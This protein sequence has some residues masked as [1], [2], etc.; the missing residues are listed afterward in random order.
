MKSGVHV[1]RAR[2]KTFC[3]FVRPCSWFTGDGSCSSVPCLRGWAGLREHTRAAVPHDHPQ[4]GPTVP[5]IVI[6]RSL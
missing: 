6:L 3:I 2:S 1:K 5:N 4:N